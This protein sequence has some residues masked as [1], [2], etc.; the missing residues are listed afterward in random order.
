MALC[1]WTEFIPRLVWAGSWR[2]AGELEWK[3]PLF[4]GIS[5]GWFA[6]GITIFWDEDAD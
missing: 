1:K 3:E 6:I 5:I 2:K 4:Y